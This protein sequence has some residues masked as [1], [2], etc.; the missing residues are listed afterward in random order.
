LKLAG[1]KCNVLH[2]L[3]Y[4]VLFST[5]LSDWRQVRETLK[6]ERTDNPQRLARFSTDLVTAGCILVWTPIDLQ[7]KCFSF[8][9]HNMET[10]NKDIQH[11]RKQ[12]HIIGIIKIG[13][14]CT[15]QT[16]PRGRVRKFQEKK[17][18]F[19]EYRNS[20]R[21]IPFYIPALPP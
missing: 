4:L 21:G 8:F 13:I 17:K 9:I 1:P 16:L 19:L 12:R 5:M 15:T 10:Q 20:F 2:D 6:G 14:H 7:T 11:L 3:G 18:T